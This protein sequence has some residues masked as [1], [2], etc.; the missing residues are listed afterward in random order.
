MKRIFIIVVI[1]M[2]S[3]V[4]FISFIPQQTESAEINHIVDGGSPQTTHTLE[5]PDGGGT[6]KLGDF[7]LRQAVPVSDAYFNLSATSNTNG[8]YPFNVKVNIGDD[9]LYEYTGVGYGAWGQQTVFSNNNTGFTY[10]FTSP[11]GGSDDSFSV[12]LPKDAVVQSAEV[13]VTGSFLQVVDKNVIDNNQ[14]NVGEVHPADMDND[15]DIDV[16]VA[17]N[18]ELVWYNNTDGKG[19][20]WLEH[21]I[22]STQNGAAAVY[23]FDI[24]DDGDQ[25]V[26]STSRVGGGFGSGPIIYYRNLDGKARTWNTTIVNTSIIANYNIEAAD[27][28]NDGDGD[29]VVASGDWGNGATGVYW[30]NNTD[31]NGSSWSQHL[32][33]PNFN[34]C[35]GLS[36]FDVDNDG[37]N[38]TVVTRTW[39]RNVV[40]FENSDGK[41][42]T[43][44]TAY[45]IGSPSGTG[46]PFNIDKGDIDKDGDLDIA[47]ASGTGTFWFQQPANPMSTWT[48]YTVDTYTAWW[49]ADVAIADVGN[50]GMGP[51]GDLDILASIQANEHDVVWYENDGTPAGNN[52]VTNVIN[53]NHQDAV[54][55]KVAEMDNKSYVDVIVGSTGT[56][57]ADDVVW[58]KLNGSFP[59]NVKLDIGSD[60]TD[61][62][63]YVTWLNT[64]QTISN[65]GQVFNNLVASKPISN[66]DLYYNDFVD[67]D[68]KVT[69]STGGRVRFSEL[70]INYDYELKVI[71]STD[72]SVRDELH[73]QTGITQGTGNVSI[74]IMVQTS[75]GGKLTI[76]DIVVKYNDYPKSIKIEG[77]GIDEDTRNN[78][79]I[80][81]TDYF[82]DDFLSPTG[83][84]YAVVDFTN[85]SIVDVV[86]K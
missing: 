1:V 86:I 69:S 43:W 11:A 26:V 50:P 31:G 83:L 44:S 18:D 3:A 73:E 32:L 30:Y 58:Y 19:T 40:W 8:E 10:S 35:R 4:N 57:S 68:F 12:K 14:N 72:N 56:T 74:P 62:W 33:A 36:I 27:M 41:A 39:P 77:Y 5:I 70:Q 24:D 81:L 6:E 52:W 79:L 61:D 37:D 51:D 60:S 49:G 28:D 59:S 34:R 82:T 78:S 21:K 15:G 76:S 65:L 80:D 55:I 67:L 25:D 7:S 22:N 23:T 42:T 66:T 9:L 85:S 64:T 48:R 13:K 20:S 75:T 2:L 46:S 17:G 47:V 45:T 63:S 38:D 16:V 84:T 29:I 53:G 54:C 71:G